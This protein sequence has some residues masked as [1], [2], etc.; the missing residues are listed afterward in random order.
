LRNFLVSKECNPYLKDAEIPHILMIISIMGISDQDVNW[1]AK[2]GTGYVL[3]KYGMTLLTHY[4]SKRLKDYKIVCSTL[5][6]RT[7]D[8]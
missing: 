4:T 5:W 6:P 8:A 2:F 7:I 3:T 1:F